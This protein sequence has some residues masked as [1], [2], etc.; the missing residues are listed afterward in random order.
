MLCRLRLEDQLADLRSEL[1]QCKARESEGA[2]QLAGLRSEL[3]ESKLKQELDAQ[4]LIELREEVKQQQ[5]E[6]QQQQ[7]ASAGKGFSSKIH[8]AMSHKYRLERDDAENHAEDAARQQSQLQQQ[9]ALAKSERDVEVGKYQRL[10]QMHQTLLTERRELQVALAKSEAARKAM[11]EVH[12]QEM[13]QLRDILD[14]LLRCSSVL[15]KE[16][17]YN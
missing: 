6:I 4:Q 15:S 3:Q 5:K 8:S 16:M 7:S 13:L 10:E 2:I 9:V 17:R 12:S 1:R 14:G 11:E